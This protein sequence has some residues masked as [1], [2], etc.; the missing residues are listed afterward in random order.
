MLCECCNPLLVS[1]L[2]CVYVNMFITKRVNN[3]PCI[4]DLE[5]QQN[6]AAT[7]QPSKNNSWCGYINQ[8]T[9]K[10]TQPSWK[11]VIVVL[12]NNVQFD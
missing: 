1:M 9:Q 7:N 10:E 8:C 4:S 3:I 11:V 6:T 12:F 2:V 5:C